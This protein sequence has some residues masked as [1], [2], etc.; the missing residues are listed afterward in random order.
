M[1][2]LS[3]GDRKR[4]LRNACDELGKAVKDGDMGDIVANHEKL[5]SQYYGDVLGQAN[6]SFIVA[7]GT[8]GIG[9]LVL[10]GTLVYAFTFRQGTGMDKWVAGIG[11]ANGIVIE[12][13]AGVTFWLYERVA[14]QFGTFHICLERTH[15]YLLAYKIAEQVK[16]NRDGAFYELMCIMANAP[17]IT[18]S[19][20]DADDRRRA[21][22]TQG[23]TAPAI[24]PP[25]ASPPAD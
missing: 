8:A 15:R 21:A 5:I 20:M 19:D 11:T 16:Q 14:R 2:L 6:T 22:A 25:S 9:F 23:P 12:F 18:R 10:I 3:L 4:E 13:I 24:N 7:C 17:M 1:K